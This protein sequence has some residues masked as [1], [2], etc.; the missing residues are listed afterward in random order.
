ML[1]LF[2]ASVYLVNRVQNCLCDLN[3]DF[4]FPFFFRET[5]KQ[6]VVDESR[7]QEAKPGVQAEAELPGEIAMVRYRK[8]SQFLPS[9]S[10][11]QSSLT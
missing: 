10:M 9:C 3:F 4:F 11:K 6:S 2:S 5:S 1:S 7:T 8:D